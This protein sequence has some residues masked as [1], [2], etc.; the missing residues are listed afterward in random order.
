MLLPTLICGITAFVVYR[1]QKTRQA[2]LPDEEA[3]GKARTN[4]MQDWQAEPSISFAIALSGSAALSILLAFAFRNDFVLWD[5]SESWIRIPVACC[6]VA[7]ASWFGSILPKWLT[8]LLR[9][10]SVAAAAKLVFPVGEA[11]EFLQD[12]SW[13]WQGTMVMATIAPWFLLSTMN[14]PRTAVI[15]LIWIACCVAGAFL[16]AQSF[17]KATEP[18]MAVACVFG[19]FGLVSFKSRSNW[20]AATSGVGLFGY[21]ACIANAQFN[22]FLGL[23][24]RLSYLAILAPALTISLAT[25]VGGFDSKSRSKLF[26]LTLSIVTILVVVG[27]IA[28]T[29]VAAGVGAEEEW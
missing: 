10:L 7:S 22:S 16:T 20:S 12:A 8:W 9:L 28:W 14:R 4:A 18:M 2:D 3:T 5:R 26:W 24:D 6:V 11:W 21:S 29:S 1:L 19:V 15:Q 25:A 13:R 23:S 17:M 27:I